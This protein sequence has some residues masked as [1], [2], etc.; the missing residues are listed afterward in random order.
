M[1]EAA[2]ILA[3]GLQQP[4]TGPDAMRAGQAAR[5]AYELLIATRPDRL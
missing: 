5:R 2:R 1:A 4:P 3:H